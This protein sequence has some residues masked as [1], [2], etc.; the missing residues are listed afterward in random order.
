MG[1]SLKRVPKNRDELG[2]TTNNHHAFI[3]LQ[4]T[5]SDSGG[6][7]SK[8]SEESCDENARSY[9]RWRKWRISVFLFRHLCRYIILPIYRK[10]KLDKD[11]A[12][13]R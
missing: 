3:V 10:P 7:D 6:I 5:S 11:I 8:I 1:G 9:L 13:S 4:T 12:L 2:E